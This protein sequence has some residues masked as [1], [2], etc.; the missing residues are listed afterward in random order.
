M[1][2]SR[3]REDRLREA[4]LDEVKERREATEQRLLADLER[5]R[6]AADQRRR[7]ERDQ[8]EQSRQWQHKAGIEVRRPVCILLTYLT[9]H[10]CACLV[11]P[12]TEYVGDG[13]VV[14]TEFR[15]VWLGRPKLRLQPSLHGAWC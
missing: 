3:E 13:P 12:L 1:L 14:K 9:V 5:E 6:R 10:R 11:F 4:L 7:E 2:E 15:L 8:V